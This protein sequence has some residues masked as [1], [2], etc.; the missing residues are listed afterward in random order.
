MNNLKRTVLFLLA[1]LIFSTVSFSKDET[2]GKKEMNGIALEKYKN[3]EHLWKLVTVRFRKDTGELRFTYANPLAYKILKSGKTNYP[4]GAIFGKVGYMTEE[5]PSFASSLVPSGARRLQLMVKNKNKYKDEGGWGFAL[6]NNEG[7]TFPESPKTQVGACF[8]CHAAVP[9]RGFVFSEIME[10]SSVK[11]HPLEKKQLPFKTISVTGL[12]EKIKK[13]I[14]KDFLDARVLEGEMREKMFQGT[15]EEIRPSLSLEASISKLPVI[16]MNKEEN[17]FSI[18]FPE[19]LEAKC[20]DGEKE[21]MFMSS[22]YTKMGKENEVQ[23]LHFC[24]TR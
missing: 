16:L 14:P 15:L 23:T 5:D 4:D 11:T 21:G 13:I 18:V 20:K 17:R 7:V 10:Q 1:P 9:E 12:S 19:N 3:F 24:Y 8:A 2:G 22:V 6:F